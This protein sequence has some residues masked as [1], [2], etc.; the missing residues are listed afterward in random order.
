MTGEEIFAGA[1][2]SVRGAST[3]LLEREIANDDVAW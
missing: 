3:F 1:P 2:T